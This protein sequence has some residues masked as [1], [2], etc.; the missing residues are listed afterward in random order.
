MN[1]NDQGARRTYNSQLT[2]TKFRNVTCQ[3]EKVY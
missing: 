2:T 3:W 1:Y